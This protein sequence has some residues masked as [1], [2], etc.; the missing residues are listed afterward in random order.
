M[1]EKRAIIFDDNELFRFVIARILKSKD[2]KVK[3][4]PSPCLYFCI[5]SGVDTCPVTTACTD[6][7]LTDQM[8]PDMTG[9][10]F[11][12]RTK[13]MQCKIPDS[14]KAIIS[15]DWTEETFGEAKQFTSYVFNKFDAKEKISLWIEHS[16]F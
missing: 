7:L 15:V 9:L 1:I 12:R 4:Y 10:E 16:H 6:F 14:R 5:Q 11:L 13:R 2:F 8:M 3:S